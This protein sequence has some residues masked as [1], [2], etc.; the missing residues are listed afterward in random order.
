M[1]KIG[2][3]IVTIILG[4][5]T[6]RAAGE[7]TEAF[8]GEVADSQCAMNVHSMTRS[9]RE[10]LKGKSMGNTPA[11]CSRYCIEHLGGKVVLVSGKDVRYMDGAETLM[12][13]LGKKVRVRGELE[14]ASNTIHVS[15]IELVE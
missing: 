2:A 4:L 9:H 7:S 8:Q 15:K 10:M 1:H 3:L 13:Y 11:D 14:K 12:Q 5:T 6:L